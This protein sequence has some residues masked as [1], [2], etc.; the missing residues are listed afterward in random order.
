MTERVPIV[1][2]PDFT[3]NILGH[4]T[5]LKIYAEWCRKKVVVTNKF[6]KELHLKLN[7]KMRG[8]GVLGCSNLYLGKLK[9]N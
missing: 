4:E 2:G 9:I 8:F 3:E 1:P 6:E 5:L 7:Y